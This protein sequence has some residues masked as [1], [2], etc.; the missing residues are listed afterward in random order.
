[1]SEVK[2]T[3]KRVATFVNGALSRGAGLTLILIATVGCD[4][5]PE[6]AG[7]PAGADEDLSY[8]EVIKR[9]WPPLPTS[10]FVAGRSATAA[11]VAAG[12]AAFVAQADGA[13][14]GEPLDIAVPQH[15]VHV[16]PEDGRRTPVFIIQAERYRGQDTLGYR[17]IV[18][19]KVG[20]ALRR[21]FVFLDDLI[22]DEEERRDRPRPVPAVG[23]R[24]GPEN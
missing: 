21:D 15:A 22:K 11:D 4:A 6:Q 7:A 3:K 17:E 9:Q 2:E 12:N 5:P 14:V 23:D 13:V 24:N 19:G 18:T 20:V 8:A 10:G 16:D 1:M